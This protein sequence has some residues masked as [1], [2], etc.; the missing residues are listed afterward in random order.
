MQDT[1]SIQAV[2]SAHY[3]HPFTEHKALAAKG[4][5]VMVKGQGIYL[6]DSEGKKLLDGMSGLWCMNVGYGRKELADVAYKQLQELPYYNSFFNTTNIPAVELSKLLVEISPPQFNHV[7]FAG[8]GSEG[9]DTIFRMVR[10]FWD[11]EGQPQRKVVISRKNGYHGSTVCGSSLG[12]MSYMHEQ[13]DLPIPGIVHIEQPYWFELGRDIDKDAFGIKAAGWLEEKILEVGADKVAAFIAEPV[14]GA[15]GVIIAPK[16]Y[17]AEIQRICDKYGILLISDEVICGFG[18][19][20]SW[21]GCETLGYKPDF[22]NFAK[23]VTSG[24]IPLGGVLVG[25]RVAKVVIEKGSDFNH[26]YTY[27]GHPVACAVAIENIR[28]LQREKV[29]ETVKNETGPYLKERFEGLKDHP[30]VGDAETLGMMAGLVLVKGKSPI[31]MFDPNLGVGMVCRGHMFSNG[32]IMRAVGDRMI[33]APPLVITKE[34]IDEMIALI[35][36]CLDATLED[37]KARG[38]V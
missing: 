9:N 19:T 7:F 27:S 11:L 28:I 29:I 25:D 6:W 16:T 5:R 10:W 38:W 26:G 15:G 24:Y 36:R 20:G 14:Q 18:R 35:R 31:E 30:L 22:I 12:G 33:I 21:F 2:D 32:M 4:A 34:E 37:L 17:W 23:G 8:S 13:G 1:K 3:L